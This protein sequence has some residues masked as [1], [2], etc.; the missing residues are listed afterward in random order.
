[1][2]DFIKVWKF[3][4]VVEVNKVSEVNEVFE[5]IEAVKVVEN[6]WIHQGGILTRNLGTRFPGNFKSDRKCLNEFMQFSKEMSFNQCT[7]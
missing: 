2:V 1:M 3:V 7:L 4:K 5:V 6:W